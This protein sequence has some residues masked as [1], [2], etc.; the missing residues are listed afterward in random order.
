M[1]A[2][3]IERT[4]RPPKVFISYSQESI[5]HNA[6]VRDFAAR[7]RKDGIDAIIDQYVPA[8]DE[9]FPRWM[10]GQIESADFVILVCTKGYLARLTRKGKRGVGN[11]VLWE[12]NLIYQ[13]IYDAGTRN[14]KFIPVLFEGSKS[15]YIPKP[16][17]SFAYNK[18]DTPEGY[19]NLYR[20]LTGQNRVPF[21]SL[22]SLL[23]IPAIDSTVKLDFECT[24]AA[25]RLSGASFEL[26]LAKN[27]HG[28]H[29]NQ[30]A[31]LGGKLHEAE[32]RLA[33]VEANRQIHTEISRCFGEFI[34][35]RSL[36]ELESCLAKVQVLSASHAQNADIRLLET[37]IQNVIEAELAL[38][39]ASSQPNNLA[40][41][42]LRQR[43]LSE[44][45]RRSPLV[46]L[47]LLITSIP[48]TAA[49]GY[50]MYKVIVYLIQIVPEL[51]NNLGQASPNPRGE[52]PSFPLFGPIT[53]P[54][55][56][57]PWLPLVIAL[58]GLL[59]LFALFFVLLGLW[60]WLTVKFGR[61]WQ[62]PEVQQTAASDAP[63]HG[64]SSN[65]SR[66]KTE[67]IQRYLQRSVRWLSHFRVL[68]HMSK[69]TRLSHIYHQLRYELEGHSEVPPVYRRAIT[70]ILKSAKKEGMEPA[71]A[72][73]ILYI[74]IVQ[75]LRDLGYL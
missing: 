2:N 68:A 18:V 49:A 58:L 15:A 45:R 56:A 14:S 64:Q 10:E 54:S 30:T 32:A 51:Y 67:L 43:L 46:L 19:D 61:L 59:L 28:T 40:A 39:L 70:R 13:H 47:L 24:Q 25:N 4:T 53:D 7:L 36:N 6:R 62:L 71:E 73:E 31:T 57:L 66:N 5:E 52:G 41:S 50:G 26:F 44:L 42:Y 35:A 9:G 72:S 17:K 74:L 60:K 63:L 8:P 20:R 22:G 3:D 37:R 65:M 34:A 12:A 11:G 29:C 33:E 1:A 21:P 38:T 69:Y 55:Y 23:L 16:L 27:L 75:F 48:L